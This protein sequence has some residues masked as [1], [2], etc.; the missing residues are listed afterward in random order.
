L[1]RRAVSKGVCDCGCVL[2]LQQSTCP[3]CGAEVGELKILVTT[4]PTSSSE[5]DGIYEKNQ[6]IRPLLNAAEYWAFGASPALASLKYAEAAEVML[7]AGNYEDGAKCFRFASRYAPGTDAPLFYETKAIECELKFTP[8]QDIRGAI[9]RNVED[10][11]EHDDVGLAE[12]QAFL[13]VMKILSESDSETALRELESIS[14]RI[15]FLA[16]AEGDPLHILRA[17]LRA[18]IEGRKHDAKGA[19]EKLQRLLSWRCD[20]QEEFS[21]RALEMI[22]AKWTN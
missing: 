6:E 8:F 5:L 16:E 18:L 22:K 9:R 7:S 12:K 17:M 13:F 21:I 2:P 4:S 20:L 19:V 11:L 3:N 14:N 1:E 10:L 15:D